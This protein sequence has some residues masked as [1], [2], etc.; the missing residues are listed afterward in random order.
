MGRR[1]VVRQR[2]LVSPFLGSNPSGPVIFF[3]NSATSEI[4]LV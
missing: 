3:R 1:Q 2:V 4:N